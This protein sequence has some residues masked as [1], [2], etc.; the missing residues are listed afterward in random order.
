MQKGLRA[1]KGRDQA[2][3]VWVAS[4]QQ[5]S[6]FGDSTVG[7]LR[8][9]AALGSKFE[10]VVKICAKLVPSEGGDPPSP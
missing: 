8:F 7:A 9:Y 5:G 6:Q 2:H 10:F 1:L 3:G 4:G